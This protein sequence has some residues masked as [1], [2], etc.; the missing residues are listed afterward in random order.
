MLI[1]RV[2]IEESFHVFLSISKQNSLIFRLCLCLLKT[3][4]HERENVKL[5]EKTHTFR[6]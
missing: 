1:R 5:D 4:K 3:L 6:L 2:I